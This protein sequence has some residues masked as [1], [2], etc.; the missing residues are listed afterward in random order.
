MQIIGILIAIFLLMFLVYKGFHLFPTTIAVS[1]I[2]ILTNGINIWE[3]LSGAYAKSFAGFVSSYGFI[4]LFGAI[5]GQVM[6]DS[7]SAKAISYK[8]LDIV[9]TK[10]VLLVTV[11]ITSILAYGGIATFVIVFTIYPITKILFENANIPR[12]LNYAAIGLGAGTYTM[13]ALPFS[14]SIQNIIPTT[15]LGTDVAAAPLLGVISGIMLFGGGYYYLSRQVK[16]AVE[17]NKAAGTDVDNIGDTKTEEG[18][19][20]DWKVAILPLII[21]IV[22]LIVTK[23]KMPAVAALVLAL[24]LGILSTVILSFK[25]F[26]NPLNTLSAGSTNGGNALIVAAAVIGF[27]GVVKAVPGFNLFVEYILSL[28]FHPLISEAIG[29]NIIA[30]IVGSATGGVQIFLETLGPHFVEMGVNPEAIHRIA[31]LASGGLDSLPHCSSVVIGLSY[32]GLT[33]KEAYK[34]FGVVT[35]LIPIL[36]TCISVALA[37]LLY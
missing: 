17:E 33:H 20:P 35:V 36:V 2:V 6:A 16:K 22:M 5:F 11:L 25:K 19:L 9:G 37:I 27:A 14:P 13:T 24:V 4:L 7:G 29:V 3:S 21:V 15:I 26:K 30:G 28:D 18:V 32:M 10:R 23:D 1:L 12:K 34:D 31:T 8:I